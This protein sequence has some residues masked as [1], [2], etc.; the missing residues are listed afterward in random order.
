MEL[1]MDK[2]RWFSLN[3]NYTAK[4]SKPSLLVVVAAIFFYPCKFDKT[5]LQGTQ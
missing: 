4:S 1:V 3:N 5:N 2:R